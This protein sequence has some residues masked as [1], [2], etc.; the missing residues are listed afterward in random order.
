MKL[1]LL[2]GIPAV[3]KFTVGKAL[4]EITGFKFLHNH[5]FADLCTMIFDPGTPAHAELNHRIRMIVY[6]TAAEK[7]LKGLIVTFN[8]YTGPRT[9][10]SNNALLAWAN[11]MKDLGGEFCLVRLSCE[12]K[13]LERRV[14]SSSRIGTRKIVEVEKL[15][16]VL[17]EEFISDKV[18][19]SIAS[20]LC[21]DNTDLSPREVAEMI[22]Q[23]YN[24]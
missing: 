24:K 13:E 10:H 18:P 20:S 4:Q 5:L 6:K 1:V 15:R 23:H 14:I 17:R 11:L 12:T 19:A 7:G 22:K 3:G 16:E 21:I 8:Y 9:E 2:Y